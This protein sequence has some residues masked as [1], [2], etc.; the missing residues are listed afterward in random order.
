MRAEKAVEEPQQQPSLISKVDVRP[1]AVGEISGVTGLV[2]LTLIS[3]V[4]P[5][6]QKTP[7]MLALI[8]QKLEQ[9]EMKAYW[10]I[11][12]SG[13]KAGLVTAQIQQQE[14]RRVFYVATMCL[15]V[16]AE[17]TAWVEAFNGFL[18][19]HAQSLGCTHLQFESTPD[20]QAVSRI[21]ESLGADKDII[22]RVVYTVDFAQPLPNE[23]KQGEEV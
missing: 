15:C 17:P 22:S 8:K 11:A 9:G 1:I 23:A 5:Q 21:A 16:H 12:P 19:L 2:V 20:N 10:L 7:Q 13:Q 14:E 4:L 18:R 6:E 3:Q